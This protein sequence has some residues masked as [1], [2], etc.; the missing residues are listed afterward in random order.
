MQIL[1][2]HLHHTLEDACQILED[3]NEIG[4]SM[5]GTYT[6]EIAETKAY[7]IIKYAN[8]CNQFIRL[9]VQKG[10]INVIRKF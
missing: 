8:L 9:I 1:Q 4:Y 7:E 2:T 10:V 6:K 3:I 5:C